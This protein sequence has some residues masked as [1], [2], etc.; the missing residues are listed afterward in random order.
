MEKSEWF[1]G[2][3][4]CVPGYDL[5]KAHLAAQTFIHL[6]VVRGF[7]SILDSMWYFDHITEGAMCNM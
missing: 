6:F 5:P 2:R 4:A 1:G 3:S 7:T